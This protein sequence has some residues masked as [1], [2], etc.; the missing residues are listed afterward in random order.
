M[1]IGCTNAEFPDLYGHYREARYSQTKHHWW[2]KTNFI[3]GKVPLLRHYDGTRS[4]NDCLYTG[5]FI[6]VLSAA[7]SGHV[8]FLEEDHYIAEDFLHVLW[9]QKQLVDDG[10]AKCSFCQDVHILSLG[11]YP[12]LFNHKEASDMVI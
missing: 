6:N 7:A 8:V 10:E 1:A 11:S 5:P 3:F 12:K 4:Q 2:W 9:L